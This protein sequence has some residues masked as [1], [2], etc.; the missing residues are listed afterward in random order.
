MWALAKREVT[1]HAPS[2]YETRFD[3]NLGY[4][5]CVV[6]ALCFVILGAAF[7]HQQGISPAAGGV[8]L[9]KQILSLF[10]ASLGQWS[11]PVVG[12][13]AFAVMFSTP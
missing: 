3:F 4:T 6:L 11:Y 7:M 9:A 5:L 13:A 2:P 1:G 12:L 10:T 8:G